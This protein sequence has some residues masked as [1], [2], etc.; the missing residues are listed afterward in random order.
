MK[1]LSWPN[2]QN[3][4]CSASESSAGIPSCANFPDMDKLAKL[5]SDA[6]F[7][8]GDLLAGSAAMAF[9]LQSSAKEHIT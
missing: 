4:L 8:S 5:S 1:N 9:I 6:Q 3:V 2:F 7:S